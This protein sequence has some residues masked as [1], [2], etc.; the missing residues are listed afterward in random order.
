[1][2][3]RALRILCGRGKDIQVKRYADAGIAR[4]P[5]ISDDEFTQMLIKHDEKRLFGTRVLAG[6]EELME[7]NVNDNNP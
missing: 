2:L 3:E 1:M 4:P 5:N 7:T 6:I